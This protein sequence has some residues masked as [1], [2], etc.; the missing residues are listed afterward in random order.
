MI[1]IKYIGKKE[2]GEDYSLSFENGEVTGEICY[3]LEK[4]AVIR[5]ITVYND[6]K[7]L[8]DGLLKS[9]LFKAL[10]KGI[11]FADINGKICDIDNYFKKCENNCCNN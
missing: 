6:D 11:K 1:E 5:S 7:D 3:N 4:T 10:V 2:T 8:Y 9:V